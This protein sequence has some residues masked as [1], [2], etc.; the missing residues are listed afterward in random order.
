MLPML[1]VVVEVI[2]EIVYPHVNE[3]IAVGILLTGGGIVGTAI[4]IVGQI[5]LEH[6]DGHQKGVSAYDKPSNLFFLCCGIMAFCII[7]TYK[8]RLLSFSYSVTV[9]LHVG[10]IY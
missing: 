3:D 8:V 4:T 7:L 1:P 9:A 2:A 5:L 10:S 6:E